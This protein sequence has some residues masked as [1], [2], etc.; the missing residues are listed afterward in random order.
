MPLEEYVILLLDSL[1]KVHNCVYIKRLAAA[2]RIIMI[3]VPPGSTHVLNV[4]DGT[5]APRVFS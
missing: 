1:T 3:E 5:R 2:F 4:L